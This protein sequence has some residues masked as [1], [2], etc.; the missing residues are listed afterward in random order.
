[1]VRAQIWRP[2]LWLQT[3]NR[4]TDDTTTTVPPAAEPVEAEPVE[5]AAPAEEPAA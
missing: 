1:M 3:S 2:A 4:M 5:T